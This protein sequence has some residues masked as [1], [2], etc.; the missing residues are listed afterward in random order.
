MSCFCARKVLNLPIPT[1]VAN[2]KQV[3]IV[4]NHNNFIIEV[5]YNAEE[6]A[7]RARLSMLELI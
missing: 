6:R 2:P 5:I 7:L 3:R 1:K 4:P